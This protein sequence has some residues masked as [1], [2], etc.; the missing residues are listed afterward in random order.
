[1][2][3]SIQEYLQSYDILELHRC[4]GLISLSGATVRQQNVEVVKICLYLSLEDSDRQRE[5]IC[6]LLSSFQ[7]RAWL[8]WY[9]IELGLRTI[10]ARIEDIKL[11]YPTAESSLS[12]IL[13]YLVQDDAINEGRFACFNAFPP[14]HPR[15]FP[16]IRSQGMLTPPVLPLHPS[17]R[18]PTPTNR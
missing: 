17:V 9:E 4:L 2:S 13:V 3:V 7:V 8:H 11:D 18:S 15:P 5:M 10:F 12:Q 6:G 1:V 14:L 16:K